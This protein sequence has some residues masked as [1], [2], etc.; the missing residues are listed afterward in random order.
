[1]IGTHRFDEITLMQNRHVKTR[2]KRLQPLSAW[3]VKSL[4]IGTNLDR[5]AGS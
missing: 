5:R 2:V 4:L 1:V 3:M